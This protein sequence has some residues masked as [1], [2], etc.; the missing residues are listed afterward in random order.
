MFA[1]CSVAD[2]FKCD[3]PTICRNKQMADQ[4]ESVCLF[5]QIVGSSHL[6][7]CRNKQMADQGESV[8][9]LRNFNIVVWPT[10][11]VQLN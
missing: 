7:I 10:H 6:K 4:G 3:E 1:Q 5:L 9:H 11:V 8:F 2:I